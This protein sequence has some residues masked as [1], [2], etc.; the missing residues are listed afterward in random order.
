MARKASGPGHLWIDFNIVL[1]SGYAALGVPSFF[2][3]SPL[4]ETWIIL[5]HLL[6][7]LMEIA[8]V[9]GLVRRIVGT[10]YLVALISPIMIAHLILFTFVPLGIQFAYI[11]PS[12]AFYNLFI[13]GM[14]RIGGGRLLF[15]SLTA[16]NIFM[17]LIH[18]INL[19]YF[20]RR[21]VAEMFVETPC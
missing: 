2:W 8:V 15:Y 4:E 17:M 5:L 1:F 10:N 6:T 13:H 9:Y 19:C 11:G 18:G 20:T 3:P 7:L 12:R 16:F 21:R 14:A